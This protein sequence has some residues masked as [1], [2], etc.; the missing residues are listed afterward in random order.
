MAFKAAGA[1]ML[2]SSPRVRGTPHGVFGGLRIGG[3][4]PACAG[5]TTRQLIE[6][7]TERDHPRVCGEHRLCGGQ[8]RGQAGSSPRVRGTPLRRP[9]VPFPTG[10]IPACAGNTE[11][12]KTSRWSPQDH[13]RVCG[14]HAGDRAIRL[15]G[16]GSSPRVRGTRRRLAHAH[17]HSGIIPACA[18]NTSTGCASSCCA[19]DHP[20]VCGEHYTCPTFHSSISG[21]SPRV[22]GTQYLSSKPVIIVGIIP[23]CAGN[24]CGR[25]Y[26]Y[27]LARDHPRVCGEHQTEVV[28]ERLPQ[29]SSPRVRG[30]RVQG[31]AVGLGRGIIPAC[32]GNTKPKS[33]TN[34][35][36]RDHPRVCGEHLAF[37]VR[38]AAARGSSPR[39]RGTPCYR[40]R[41]SDRNGIIPACAGNTWSRP[42]GR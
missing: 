7:L 11:T 28:H 13:P 31:R 21:S 15:S 42:M 35:C 8:L 41:G 12:E 24:T 25:S 34:A 18:G 19:R 22:R 5:N 30:T 33:S 29:G 23:A 37:L 40:R 14:E 9:R 2:G 39:V 38:V 4:I 20:R 10:I 27:R 32:A 26:T 36:R 16:R 1:V 6:S 17:L 3:I